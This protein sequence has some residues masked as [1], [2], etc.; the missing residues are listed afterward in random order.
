MFTLAIPA[1]GLGLLEAPHEEHQESAWIKRCQNGDKDAFEPLVRQN[2]GKIQR[3]VW[4]MLGERRED[5]DDVVQEIF[6]KAYIALPRF[7]GDARFST[8]VYR[9][10]VNHCRDYLKRGGPLPLELSEEKIA[11]APAPEDKDAQDALRETQ[12]RRASEELQELLSQLP[13]K[14]RRILVMRELEG[15][16]YDE[17]GEVLQIRPGTVRSRLNRARANI[18]R[19]AESTRGEK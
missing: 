18:L 12:E 16:S 1:W 3:L 10:A 11:D 7:R 4:G 5:T 13:E 6:I 2:A 19:A 17:I 14:H 15:M 8:W 9:I